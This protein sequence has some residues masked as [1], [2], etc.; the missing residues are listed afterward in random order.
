[1]AVLIGEAA[2]LLA[3]ANER[4]YRYF[5]SIE[6]FKRYVVKDVLALEEVDLAAA[7]A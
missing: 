2:E 7:R 3:L 5:T 4:G 1:M 6:A